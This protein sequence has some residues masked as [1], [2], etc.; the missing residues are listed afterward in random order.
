MHDDVGALQQTQR[1]ERQQLRIARASAD[2]PDLTRALGSTL[3]HDEPL[4]RFAMVRAAGH[5]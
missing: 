1:L 5:V 2:Q 3:K 4:R